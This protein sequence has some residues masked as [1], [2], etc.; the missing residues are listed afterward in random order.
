MILLYHPRATKPRNRR[1]P[2]SVL[3]L[4][5][6][7]EGREDYKI[8]DGNADANATATL[9]AIIQ[10]EPV[11]L[12]AVSVMPG[13]QMVSAME[14]CKSV[15]TR[16]PYIPIVWGG[17]FPSIYTDATLNAT[18][19]DFAIR[20]QGEETLLEV[21]EALRGRIEFENIR[22]L[23]FKGS[24]GTYRH[25]PERPM[26]GPDSFPWYPFHRIDA[27]A[28][29]RPSFF[30]RRTAVH[31][32]SIGCPFQCGFCGVIS[33]YGSV[34]RMESPARTQA[35]LRHLV[36]NYGVDSIQFY[37]NN[38]FLQ[39][40]H[41]REQMDRL[42][43]LGLSWWCEARIDLMLRYSDRT[44]EAIRR[45]GCTMIFFGAESGSD[46][47]L[48]E[49]T[50]QLK[51]EQT[52][53]LAQRIKQFDIIP[54]F[55]FVVGNPKNPERDTAECLHFIRKIKQLNPASEIIIY[56]YTPVP[57]RE[58]MYGNV[59]GQ[60]QFPSTPDEW[61]TERWQ[62]FAT[63]KDPQ[64][65]WLKP[66]TKRRIDNFRLVV[67]SRWPTVQDLRLSAWGRRT[68]QSLSAWRYRFG[69]YDF[70]YEL[71]L[72]QWLV[73]LRKPEVESL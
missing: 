50:K 58:Q 23:S 71:E 14:T 69:V 41:A 13:P 70:P 26:K 67:S 51:T 45:A 56:P 10:S 33:A 4:A 59:E 37:D 29:I 40:E 30:G 31:Q 32:A 54:E 53:A 64:T 3:A 46:W 5:A 63:R 44:F 24:S 28:Y 73:H 7:L 17:Y 66:S 27:D 21:L 19:V 60:V 48:Q 35:I 49:M 1:F 52:L 39:E 42:T 8:I 65:S 57:Q 12:L 16:F 22:G 25:N 34:E 43:P 62:A 61:A 15:R 11:E 36:H 72:M 18:Y 9:L 68:L 55:S 38:F 47:V 2:L 6:V 20:G